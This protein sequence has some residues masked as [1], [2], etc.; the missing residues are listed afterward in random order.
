MISAR[1]IADRAAKGL[2]GR[3]KSNLNR[4][5]QT[6]MKSEIAK[7]SSKYPQLRSGPLR[8]VIIAA[9]S[10][11]ATEALASRRVKFDFDIDAISVIPFL[12]II[13]SPLEPA[14]WLHSDS[15]VTHN[16]RTALWHTRLTTAKE[17]FG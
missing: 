16:G 15:P 14:R 11:A 5:L 3:N 9:L 2:A 17:Y 10:L 13:L 1:R 4:M 6:D 7:L 12:P 8:E